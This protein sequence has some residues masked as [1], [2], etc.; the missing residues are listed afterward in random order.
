HDVEDVNNMATQ[1]ANATNEQKSTSAEIL[2]AV[3]K[4]NEMV[5]EIASNAQFLADFSVSIKERSWKLRDTSA[6]FTVKK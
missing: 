4:I 2:N 1:I 5:Q 3:S 6:R